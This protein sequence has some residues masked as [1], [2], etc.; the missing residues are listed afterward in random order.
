[1]LIG[2]ITGEHAPEHLLRVVIHVVVAVPSSTDLAAGSVAKE[3][4]RDFPFAQAAGEPVLIVVPETLEFFVV[5]LDSRVGPEVAPE[6]AGVAQEIG[7]G[8]PG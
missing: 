3:A 7:S 6:T 2:V 4:R 8:K 1:M 5:Q